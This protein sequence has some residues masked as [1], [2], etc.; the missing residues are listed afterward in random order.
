M[1]RRV[2]DLHGLAVEIASWCH[3]GY[4]HGV[5]VMMMFLMNMVMFLMTM[6]MIMMMFDVDR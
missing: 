5:L 2:H 4:P 1:E 6:R 3:F